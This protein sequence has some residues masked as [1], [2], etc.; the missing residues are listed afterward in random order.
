MSEREKRRSLVLRRVASGAL[1]LD[2]ATRVL[3]LSYRHMKRVW[4]RFRDEGTEGLTH[5]GKGRPSNRAFDD[6][7][8]EEVLRRYRD[9]PVGTGP[10]QF[11]ATLAAQGI[12]VDHE[13]LRRW[14]L[15]SGAWTLSRCKAAPRQAEPSVRGFGE[16]LTLV[17]LSDTWLGAGLP[18][19]FLLFL[20]DEATS[21]MLFALSHDDSCESAMRLLGAWIERYGLPAALRCQR[22]FASEENGHLTL[23]QQLTGGERRSALARACDRLG[24]DMTILGAAPAKAWLNDRRAI[25]DELRGELSRR[26]AATVEQASRALLG[27]AGDALNGPFADRSQVVEDYHVPIVDGTAWTASAASSPTAPSRSATGSS[28]WPTAFLRRGRCRRGSSSRN[29]WTGPSTSWTPAGSCR[30]SRWTPRTSRAGW[31]SE[32]LHGVPW[33]GST[34]QRKSS[35]SASS[36][37]GLPPGGSGVSCRRTSSRPAIPA[38]R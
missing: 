25:L 5:K 6:G 30:S 7:F 20:Y 34:W 15:D 36:S 12:L 10:T 32:K 22:H 18:P 31:P 1:T 16:L 38:P 23:E 35:F 37:C 24:V 17:S 11:A 19:S 13:T 28:A 9:Q 29:G 3:S 4:K 27:V 14:L 21:R 2:Q 8:R 33:K 26:G